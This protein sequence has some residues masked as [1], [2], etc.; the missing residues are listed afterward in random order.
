MKQKSRVSWLNLGDGN[1][2]YFHKTVKIRNSPNLIKVLKD[3]HGNKVTDMEKIKDMAICFYKR[4]LGHT[5]H[6]FCTVQAN[7]VTQLVK[8]K[9]FIPNVTFMEADVTREEVYIT[10]F[11]YE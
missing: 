1:N 8:K 3:E 6:N 10:I 5:Y 9:F 2:S 4:L 11:F 7:R